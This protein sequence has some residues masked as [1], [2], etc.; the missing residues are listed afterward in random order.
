MLITYLSLSCE[1][2]SNN[3]VPLALYRQWQYFYHLFLQC[4][5]LWE[6]NGRLINFYTY[7]QTYRLTLLSTVYLSNVTFHPMLCRCRRT[8]QS[9]TNNMHIWANVNRL[10]YVTYQLTNY[11]K[12]INSHRIDSIHWNT[13]ICL[14]PTTEFTF[15]QSVHNSLLW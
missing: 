3:T 5:I 15:M 8:T 14:W 1:C 6:F 12:Y 9:P 2:D 10:L 4:S 11:P 13:R 7:L